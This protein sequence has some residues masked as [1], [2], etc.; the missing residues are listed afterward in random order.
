MQADQA[1]YVPVTTGYV[2]TEGDDIYYE[3]RGYGTPLLMISG[4][5]GDAG[6]FSQ[7]ADRLADEYK[8][9]TYDRRGNSRS[10]RN[11][12]QNFEISQQSRDAVAVLRAVGETAAFVFGNSGG[13]VIALDMAKTQRQ[14]VIAAVVHEPPVVCV[15]PDAAKWRRY[16]AGLYR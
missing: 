15:L 6:F 12:P 3:M 4:G 14:A 2:A 7:V 1:T 10:S 16:F 13:A 11:R 9:I 8:V 5:G